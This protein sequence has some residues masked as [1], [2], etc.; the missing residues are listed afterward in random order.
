MGLYSNA[1]YPVP[2][3]PFAVRRVPGRRGW[4]EA[5]DEHGRRLPGTWAANR[6]EAER[7][8]WVVAQEQRLTEGELLALALPSELR[9]RVA[10]EFEAALE[11]AA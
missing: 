4:W 2:E 6:R 1:R 9:R 5:V 7:Q 10:A 3:T 8:A 11:G